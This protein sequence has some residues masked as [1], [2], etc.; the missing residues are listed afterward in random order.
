MTT[1]ISI[2]EVKPLH[3]RWLRLTFSDGAVKDVDVGQVLAQGGV[4]APIRDNRSIFELVRIRPGSRTIEWPGDVDLDPDVLYG[5]LQPAGGVQI[6]RRT[7]RE[8]AAV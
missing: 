2:T 1:L 4:F 5:S 7:V 3:E 8:P 6:P